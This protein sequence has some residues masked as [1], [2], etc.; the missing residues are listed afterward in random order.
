[1][2]KPKIALSIL[3]L[4]YLGFSLLTYKDYGITL[5]EPRVYTR[6][7]QLLEYWSK[8][9][10]YKNT[11]EPTFNL[12]PKKQRHAPI[13]SRYYN[14]YAAVVSV[15]NK[16]MSFERYHFFNMVLASMLIFASFTAVYKLYQNVLF[17]SLIP[18][19]IFLT[20]R[21]LGHIPANPKDVP[22]AVIYISTLF[23]IYFVETS[24]GKWAKDIIIKSLILGILFGLTQSLRVVGY[25]VYLL[26]L[27]FIV[28]KTYV[29][30]SFKHKKPLIIHY[31]KVFFLIT[32]FAHFLMMATWPYIGSNFVANTKEALVGSTNFAEWNKEFLFD[33]V[34]ITPETRPYVYLFTW[35]ALT[36]PFFF[37]AFFIAGVFLLKRT[38]QDPLYMLFLASFFLH[39]FLYTVLKPNIYNGLRH[40]LFLLVNLVVL[41]GLNFINIVEKTTKEKVRILLYGVMVIC[42]G[43]VI[44]QMA[45]LHPY[46]Y[47]YFNKIR[48]KLG[49]VQQRYPLDYW[50][51]SY[52][53]AA[54]WIIN[55]MENLNIEGTPLVLT[56]NSSFAVEY[57]GR[58]IYELTKEASK[59]DYIIC[60]DENYNIEPTHKIVRDGAVLNGVY[61]ISY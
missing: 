60:Q 20:P 12:E 38:Y 36:T 1:V 21:F 33:G 42:L 2:T 49:K 34:T 40:Y 46:E 58:G 61:K 39:I 11:V 55:D 44:W 54:D 4:L 53:E 19:F 41:S 15:L 52:K 6:G 57:Y 25:S 14:S 32:V 51:A 47:I 5:D 30:S 31:L 45:N 50:G 35:L 48:G 37:L 59:A 9:T 26:Y 23:A 13:L 22:F 24:K 43:S 27:F 7:Q 8:K 16:H 18:I 17:A 29:A 28:H 3:L 10:S 56:C